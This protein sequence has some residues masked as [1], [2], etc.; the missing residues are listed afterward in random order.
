MRSR[1]DKPR[2]TLEDLMNPKGPTRRWLNP[3]TNKYEIVT[4]VIPTG[5]WDSEEYDKLM[6]EIEINGEE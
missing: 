1:K 2:I 3:L 4:E 5:T 6:S